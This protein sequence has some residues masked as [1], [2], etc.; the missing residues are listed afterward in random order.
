MKMKENKEKRKKKKEKKEYEQ[1]ISTQ[2]KELDSKL[3]VKSWKGEI[4]VL[5]WKRI[6]LE[7][8]GPRTIGSTID[9]FL[10]KMFDME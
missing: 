3:E 7:F 9:K 4:Q 6:I 5:T 1:K 10:H 8:T 2:R